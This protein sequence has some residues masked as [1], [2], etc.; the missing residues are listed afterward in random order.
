MWLRGF[1]NIS[2]QHKSHC[3]EST[4]AW[5]PIPVAA[6][7]GLGLNFVAG[8]SDYNLQTENKWNSGRRAGLGAGS[9]CDMASL[10]LAFESLVSAELV[11][12]RQDSHHQS[13]LSLCKWLRPTS[14]TLTGKILLFP[15]S[16]SGWLGY[17]T[18][19]SRA[20]SR[21]GAYKCRDVNLCT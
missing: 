6:I 16:P 7:S 12:W 11:R 13:H 2:D 1:I 14:L 21:A 8:P 3:I 17:L 4:S 9:Q 5:A 15:P 20:K 10:R 19:L 18:T